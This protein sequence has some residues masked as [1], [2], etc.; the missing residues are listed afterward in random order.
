[1][2]NLGDEAFI[3]NTP[4]NFILP[5]ERV[6]VRAVIIT[7]T[8]NS[9]RNAVGSAG[10]SEPLV[11][12]ASQIVTIDANIDSSANIIIKAPQV[13]F[14]GTKPVR[15]VAQNIMIELPEGVD[16][17]SDMPAANNQNVEL[18]AT[19]GDIML[20]NNINVGFGTLKLEATGEIMTPNADITIMGNRVVL[21]A[22]TE[23]TIGGGLTIISMND[24]SLAR[25]HSNR[26]QYPF[27]SRRLYYYVRCHH[28]D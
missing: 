2:I 12:V 23:N 1:M 6:E 3:I 21:D 11:L 13:V 5:N 17:P 19:S 4:Q 22:G 25:R 7:I 15:L 10:I 27:T 9:I 26:W 28:H 8:A 18:V 20:N 16:M 14:S 24:I